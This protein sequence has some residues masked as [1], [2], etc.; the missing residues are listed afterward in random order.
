[1]PNLVSPQGAVDDW[2]DGAPRRSATRAEKV[3][4][5]RRTR[6]KGIVV[7]LSPVGRRRVV[8]TC[9][10]VRKRPIRRRY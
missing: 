3:I 1:M 6:V 9:S 4:R 8:A 2:N 5:E 10:S 7:M